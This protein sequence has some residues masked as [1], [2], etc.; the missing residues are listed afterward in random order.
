MCVCVVVVVEKR[1]SGVRLAPHTHIHS[2]LSWVA[3]HG[4]LSAA[5]SRYPPYEL[6]CKAVCDFLQDFARVAVSCCHRRVFNVVVL[7]ICRAMSVSHNTV[8]E[9]LNPDVSKVL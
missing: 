1:K 6:K 7:K 2:I 5:E 4:K 3:F 8:Q 9:S